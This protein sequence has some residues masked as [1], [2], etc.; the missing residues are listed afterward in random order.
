MGKAQTKA[1]VAKGDTKPR[2][3]FSAIIQLGLKGQSLATQYEAQIGTR[4]SAA[5]L[6][7]FAADLAALPTVV[8]AVLITKGGSVQLTAAQTAALDQGYHL[9][10]GLKT[11]VKSQ[12]P[13]KDVLLAYGVG[14]R[15]NRL[16][17]K[18]VLSG[19][20]TIQN[21]ITAEPAEAQ[22]FDITAADSTAITNA[23]ATINK[24]DKSQEAGRA[25]APQA[26]KQRNATA[27]RVLAGVKKIAGAG[28]RTFVGDTT[29]YA[30]FEALITKHVV[31]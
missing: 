15:V 25:A 2:K 4:L 5:F 30:N 6:T 28:M 13:D 17:V 7:S 3:D 9:L 10:K 11:T 16:I 29:T 8:P 20:Q 22:S 19:L 26:T 1:K 14:T 18:E 12:N 31:T 27:R 21:R 23:V 24:A